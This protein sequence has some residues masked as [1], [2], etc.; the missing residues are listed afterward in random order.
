MSEFIS[1]ALELI[2][3][4]NLL[5]MNIG[6]FVGIIVGALPGLNPV[7]GITLMLP[8]TYTLESVP[9]ILL[10]LGVY[11]GATYGG[12]ITAILINTPGTGAAMATMIDGYP[13]AQQGRAGDALKAAL[14]AST[15]GGILSC[16]C[17]IFLAPAISSFALNFHSADYFSL[18]LF[19]LC[20]VVS[21]SGDSILKGLI[22][23]GIGLL[24][25]TV[26]IDTID[27]IPRFMFG[28]IE[29]LAGIPTICV[30]MGAF[31]LGNCY[32]KCFNRESG[33]VRSDVQYQK[34][35]VK[36]FPMVIKN[37]WLLLRS[38]LMG[39]FIG[40][41]PGT[42]AAVASYM[43]Y[44]VLV[45]SEKNEEEKKTYGNGNIKGVLAPEAANNGVTGATLIP[46]LTLGIPGD[47]CVAI[48]GSAL[49]LHGITPGPTLFR[50]HP[51]WVYCLMG[52]LLLVNIFML[53]QGS[54]LV[55]AF[56]NIS[57]L[58]MTI[59]IPCIMVFCVV[60]V[61][62]SRQYLFDVF[63]IIG[64]SVM[65]YFLRRCGF[66]LQPMT[67]GL[68]L[69]QLAEQNFRRALIIADG[70][71]SIFFTR[72]ISL[73]LLIIC[74]VCLFWPRLKKLLAA[75]KAKATA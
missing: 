12:S 52:G 28:K 14:V 50:D 65:G 71:A 73:A 54:Y 49:I 8:F 51:F 25:S 32:T 57:K 37:F 38:A 36:T 67:I 24:I 29:L 72:P 23:A 27:G 75:R 74:V 63:L 11:C 4:E 33:T 40:A 19:G 13:L 45:S 69:G 18:C 64:F 6:M 70:D 39:S 7:I 21:I 55:K 66:P 1:V 59:L 58:P 47:N 20:M 46:M 15:F 26:G 31:A 22:M 53:I 5:S 48:I 62:T 34:A 17:L 60:G 42:G 2:Q 10:L 44:N 68:V 61:F 9:A 41:V 30:M 35:T 3:L 56:A 43:S 16:F